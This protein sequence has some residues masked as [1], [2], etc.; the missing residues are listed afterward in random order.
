[1]ET[2]CTC[3]AEFVQ[4][5]CVAVDNNGDP[6][7]DLE[8]Q[9]KVI[10]TSENLHVRQSRRLMDDGKYVVFDDSFI[11]TIPLKIAAL[12]ERL[13]VKGTGSAGH[14]ETQFVVSADTEC[15]CHVYKISGPDT[16]A[17]E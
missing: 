14:F 4:I 7:T 16:V 11:N 15:Q 6:T 13:E 9:V 5:T 8:I 3:S 17:V 10:R 1:M 12:G 2:E